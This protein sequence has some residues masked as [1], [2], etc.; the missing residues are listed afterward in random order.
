MST[1]TVQKRAF[2]VTGMSCAACATAVEEIA[3]KQAGVQKASVNFAT[4]TL[5]VEVDPVVLDADL[6]QQQIRQG[7]YDLIVENREEDARALQEAYQHTYFESIKRDTI[8]S[9]V[10]TTPV[11]VL[12]MFWMDFPNANYLMML[13]SAPV[14]FGLGSRFFIGAWKQLMI[15]RANMD[16]LV[17]LS[18]GIAYLFSSFN[19]LFPKH[20]HSLGLHDQVYFEASAVVVTFILLGKWLEER[21]KSNT[22]S[23]IKKLMGLQPSEVLVLRGGQEVLAPIASIEIGEKIRVRPGERIAVDGQ[24]VEG[25]SFVDESMLSGEAIPVSKTIGDLVFSG[26]MNQKGSLL[27]EAKKVGSATLLARI[28]A[29]VR[30]AQGSKA[31]VQRQVD[32]IAAVFVPVVVGISVL[33]FLIWMGLGGPN[34]LSYAFLTSVTVLVIA[35][36]CALGLATPTAVMVGVGKGA[37]NGI[38]IKDAESLELAHKIDTLVLDKTGTITEGKPRV[39]GV[40][41]WEKKAAG[42]LLS[43]ESRSEHPLAAAIVKALQSEGVESAT[44]EHFASSTGKGVECEGG[45]FAGS[46]TAARTHGVVLDAFAEQLLEEWEAAAYTVVV[47]SQQ[48]ILLALFAIA[49]PIKA[50]AAEA[51]RALQKSG[52]RIWM[53]TGDQPRTAEAVGRQVGINQVM[54]G[55]LPDQKAAFIESEKASGRVVAMVGDGI[56]DA[57]ALALADVSI[58]MGQGTDVAMEVAKMTLISGDLRQVAKALQLSKI[59]VRAIRQNLFWAFIYNLIGLPLAAGLL[60]PWNGF[61]LNP[62]IAGGA[63]A[64]SSVSVVSNSLRLRQYKL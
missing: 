23:A 4:Q 42:V 34:A 17:A 3:S 12:G 55:L 9:A 36:P 52:I 33:N 29:T 39:V 63:M 45:Y 6:L 64:L 15:R 1:S 19:T 49:D 60:Y 11:V 56:N 26:T 47:F 18:T 57:Q 20:F 58:A 46:P 54:A 59:T 51:I 28:I 48:N 62:M 27:F 5:E 50:G 21:A 14:V 2:P 38:L 25:N 40:Q 53:L 35:C 32:Q 43:L 24:V 22:S 31:P 7:G 30:A 8:W 41:W 13:L 37:E 16:T 61:L 44:I 10:L